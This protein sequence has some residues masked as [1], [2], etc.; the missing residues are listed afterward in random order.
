M[1]RLTG[2]DRLRSFYAEQQ[3]A[4]LGSPIEARQRDRRL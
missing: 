2:L 1:K 3:N 4:L